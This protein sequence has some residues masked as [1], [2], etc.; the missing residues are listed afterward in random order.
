[1]RMGG[2]D[3]KSRQLCADLEPRRVKSLQ[4]RLLLQDR[5][6]SAVRD[7][8][9]RP[10]FMATSIARTHRTTHDAVAF[11]ALENYEAAELCGFGVEQ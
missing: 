9:L 1:M 4:A 3:L 7:E 10:G 8:P 11:D 6:L 2:A 5:Q